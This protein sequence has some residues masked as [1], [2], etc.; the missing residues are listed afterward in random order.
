MKRFIIATVLIL[1]F[2]PITISAADVYPIFGGGIK[3]GNG[4]RPVFAAFGG[5]NIPI[6]TN[7]LKD[8]QFFTREVIF[9][10]NQF[11]TETVSGQGLTSILMMR[12]AINAPNPGQRSPFTELEIA[13]GIGLKYMINDGK[14]VKNAVVKVESG[15][16]VWK[17]FRLLVGVD[18]QPAAVNDI[19]FPYFALDLSTRL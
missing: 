15:A 10:D 6:A 14:D 16:T 8:Y 19:W 13:A 9:Y 12:K 17:S 5:A 2:L 4:G 3:V 11:G 1:T 7:E 18:Y